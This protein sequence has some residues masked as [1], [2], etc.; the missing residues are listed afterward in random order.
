MPK[1]IKSREYTVVGGQPDRVTGACMSPLTSGQIIPYTSQAA[2][3]SWI[4][5]TWSVTSATSINAAVLRGWNVDHKG[6]STASQTASSTPTSSVSQ[7][8][9]TSGLST[10]AKSGIGAGAAIVVI[11]IVVGIFFFFRRKRR[12]RDVAGGSA[13]HLHPDQ[14]QTHEAPVLFEKPAMAVHEIHSSARP[15]HGPVELSANQIGQPQ[16]MSKR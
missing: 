13:S 5:A 11:A 10:G 6:T 14:P 9:S 2:N 15:T 1:L 3:G 16:V 8:T 12:T 4:D 7:G